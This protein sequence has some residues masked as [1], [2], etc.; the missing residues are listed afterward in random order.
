MSSSEE[1]DSQADEAEAKT[2]QGWD[3]E[4]DSG[5]SLGLLGGRDGWAGG[6]A[7]LGGSIGDDGARRGCEAGGALD[8]VSLLYQ[9]KRGSV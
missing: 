5:T 2:G 6:G 4:D 3:T 8:D 7:E 9:R 1:E